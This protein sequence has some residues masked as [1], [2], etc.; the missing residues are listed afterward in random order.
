MD[1]QSTLDINFCRLFAVDGQVFAK[2]KNGYKYQ[3][4]SI[5]EQGIIAMWGK[6]TTKKK[7]YLSVW[8]ILL[9]FFFS[10]LLRQYSEVNIIYVWLMPGFYTSIMEEKYSLLFSVVCL[11]S[12]F[13]WRKLL[14]ITCSMHVGLRVPVNLGKKQ[15]RKGFGVLIRPSF[16]PFIFLFSPCFFLLLLSLSLARLLLSTLYQTTSMKYSTVYRWFFFLLLHRSPFF[17]NEF[18]R[19][20]S[21]IIHHNDDDENNKLVE[22]YWYVSFAWK[23]ILTLHW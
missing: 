8:G 21:T 22:K 1:M 20:I 4:E 10:F 5:N 18:L 7:T 23:S 16:F 19:E 15:Y 14:D 11:F 12:Y 2:K 6:R 17:L 9:L 3:I 13:F